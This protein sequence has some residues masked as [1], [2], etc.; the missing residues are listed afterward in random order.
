M[1]LHLIKLC[2]GADSLADLRDWMAA[3]HD[4]DRLTAFDGIEQIGEVP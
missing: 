3:A 1:T 2:V 4:G